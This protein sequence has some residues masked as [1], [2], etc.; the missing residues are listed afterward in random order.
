MPKQ[1]GPVYFTGT[2]GDACFYKMDG[3]YYVRKKSSLSGKRVKE[4]SSFELTRV[5]ADLLGQ[6]S[7]LAAAVYR[8]LPREQKKLTLYR[9]MTGE[10][11]QML[12]QGVNAEVISARLQAYCAPK[13]VKTKPA[14]RKRAAVKTPGKHIKARIDEYT[15]PSAPAD[16]TH[17]HLTGAAARGGMHVPGMGNIHLAFPKQVRVY[18]TPEGKLEVRLTNRIRMKKEHE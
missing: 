13:I 14:E 2:R 18:I 8:P 15:Q 7:R 10:A 11:L 17:K 12:K 1:K 3:Q 9:A 6:A 4:S 16:V 5:Y